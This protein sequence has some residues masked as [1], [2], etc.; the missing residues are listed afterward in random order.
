[1]SAFHLDLN[2]PGA[3][4][5]AAPA[6]AGPLRTF[7][8]RGLAPSHSIRRPGFRLDLFALPG[9]TLPIAGDPAAGD[10]A[11]ACGTFLYKGLWGAAA[12]AA[13]LAD[14]RQGRDLEPGLA[15]AFA[16]LI[17]SGDRLLL[18]TDRLGYYRVYS[19]ARQTRFS[20]SYLALLEGEAGTALS[21]QEL[22]EYV[23]YGFF[24]HARTLHEG[25]RIVDPDRVHLLRPA[26]ASRDR[27]AVQ[28]PVPS[29]ARFDALLD[30]VRENLR[31]YFRMLGEAFAG[32]FTSALSGG[33][34][35]RLLLAILRELG[36]APH[37][38]VYGGADHPD[39]RVAK[40]VAAGEGLALQH[41]DKDA[42]PRV[43]PDRWRDLVERDFHFF[44][45]LK[46]TGVFDNGTDY[47]TRRARAAAAKL[48]LNGAGGE[49]YRE[50]WNL[51]DRGLSI[52]RFLRARYD[53]GDFG[54]CTDRFDQRDFFARLEEKVQRL[55]GIDRRRISRVELEML[56]PLLRNRFAG[57]NT[58]INNQLGPA[59]LP[60][61]E[62]RF[63]EQSYAIPIRFKQ[64]GCFNAALIRSLDPALA[65][66]PS[67]YGF[68]FSDPPSAAMKLKAVLRQNVP[69][70]LRL[71][72]RRSRHVGRDRPYYLAGDYQRELFGARE[73]AIREYLDPG[74]IHDPVKRA[75]ALTVE[76]LIG[77][78]PPF[79]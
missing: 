14:H 8:R 41:V 64:Y 52:G 53:F 70:G 36:Y 26:A 51:P 66:Y 13:A 61:M 57:A 71:R 50:I 40:A 16:L 39:V 68:N 31:D 65:R 7:V 49:I 55:L 4:A 22:Y 47:E 60:F 56:F 78:H 19:D 35:S 29:R 12:L 38:Y 73:L 3:G 69:V 25:V 79:A 37:L 2:V 17:A 58:S 33:Y 42:A 24:F 48:Q 11:V 5:A 9:G 18:L 27:A 75:R 44:D 28:A 46:A 10:F 45:G 32:S 21:P 74:R 59:I 77:G 62:P 15:G 67:A 54:F 34:D 23:F 30:Q 43:P 1:M 76:L 63:V 72:R 6:G 20:S